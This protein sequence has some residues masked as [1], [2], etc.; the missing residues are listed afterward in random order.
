MADASSAKRNLAQARLNAYVRE[1]NVAQQ[2]LAENNLAR[3]LRIAR[4]ASDPSQAKRTTCAVSSG[5]T[6]GSFARTPRPT[7][8]TTKAPTAIE[9]SRT[10]GGWLMAAG[11]R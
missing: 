3:A 10:D 1:I 9:F 8:S 5:V 2:A 11:A 7:L 6:S 4:T